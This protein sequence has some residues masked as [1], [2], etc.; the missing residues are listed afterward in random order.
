MEQKPTFA[1][2]RQNWAYLIFLC[3]AG[4]FVV[5]R[6][7]SLSLCAM[8][9]PLLGTLAMPGYVLL[10]G[11]KSREW[12]R[13]RKQTICAGLGLM[14]LGYLQKVMVYWA[15]LLLDKHP[16]F[17]PFS[18]GGV[19]WVLLVSGI[20]LL[21]AGLWQNRGWSS[22][23]LLAAAVAVGLVGG[24]IKPFDSF[25]CL[26]QL[27][28]YLPFFALGRTLEE[29]RVLC[30]AEEKKR[31]L[32]A[33]VV[34]A[35][36]VLGCA[37][38]YRKL[39]VLWP[40]VDGDSWYGAC[41]TFSGKLLPLGMVFRLGWYVAA[42]LLLWAL[43]CLVPNKKFP[44]VTDQG[45]RALSGY[46]WFMPLAYLTFGPLLSGITMK[47]LI[48]SGCLSLG[49]LL[50][51]PCRRGE[52]L[53]R[54]VVNAPWMALSDREQPECI[55]G[56]SFYRRHK[57]GIDMTLLFTL[58]FVVAAVAYV[59]PFDSN[60]KSL[61]WKTDGMGQQYP[62]MFYCKEYLLSGLRS[63]LETGKLSFPQ[64]DFTLGFGMSPLDALRR[65]PFMLLSLLG[66]EE[67]M[68]YIAG[69]STVL[70]LYVCG[71]VFLWFCAT[72]GKR[73]KLPVLM[74][75]LVYVFSGF[76]IF[77]SPR[78]PYF[79][80]VLMTYLV[81]MLIGAERFLQKRKYGVFVLAVF[82]QL[83]NGYYT[84][85][86]NGLILAIYLLVRL[87]CRYGKDICRIVREILRLIGLY[88]WGAAMAMMTLLPSIVGL[89][90]S[91]R[92]P[93]GQ[94]IELFYSNAHY[95]KMFTGLSLEFG[96]SGYWTF[97]SL[98]AIGWIA[99]ILLFLRR[100]ERLRPL[101]TGLAVV[102]VLVCVPVFGLIANGFAYVCNRW[103][104]CIPLL[105]ALILVEMAPEF[106]NLSLRDKGVIL[107]IVLVYSAVVVT[108]PEGIDTVKTIGLVL[109]GLT[110]LVVLLMDQFLRSRRL[111]MGILAV[112][113]VL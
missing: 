71:L 42:L 6:K 63:L 17:Y 35:A 5:A 29:E 95:R 45:E 79:T 64:W 72:L 107:T 68:E 46:F 89:M 83:F 52:R 15:Q 9:Y 87:G 55:A 49:L 82:L 77:A 26:G 23:K 86:I 47:N 10:L 66:N 103:A 41:K 67:T 59:Y 53:V 14:A 20:Y 40:I 16:D 98:A 96:G 62:M 80:T 73:D 13:G 70:R 37:L 25:L 92:S 112:I 110:A 51:A 93:V 106:L 113:A 7:T 61:I 32:P 19:A 81:L 54:R 50:L 65:E 1:A 101:K 24:L 34:L 108:R 38:L 39:K 56:G 3:A 111:R 60:G 8:A 48:I 43:F 21:L 75:S 74:G 102:T 33:L 105:V 11:W 69:F 12:Y 91:S 88:A 94:Q 57:W 78:Q 58:A 97:L 84:A 109:L 100:Q 27:C 76:A 85:Y 18:T 30:W 4:F 22:R 99:C 90:G 104:F 2:K 28:A 31:R 44:L 36:A